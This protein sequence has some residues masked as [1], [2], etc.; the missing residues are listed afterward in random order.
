MNTSTF[1]WALIGGL[2][3]FLF[4]ASAQLLRYANSLRLAKAIEVQ[5]LERASRALMEIR[6]KNA[7]APSHLI[8]AIS[9][10][11]GLDTWFLHNREEVFTEVHLQ[12]APFLLILT[13]QPWLYE[14]EKQCSNAN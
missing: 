7:E 11:T 9:R 13:W 1:E 4:A 12:K 14:H 10:V 5:W 2:L 3:M 8:K 6:A